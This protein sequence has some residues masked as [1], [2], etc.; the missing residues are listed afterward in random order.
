M[1]DDMIGVGS[2]TN[3]AQVTVPAIVVDGLRDAA[4]AEIG[5]PGEALDTAAF[6]RA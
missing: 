5:S 1:Q 6:A 3:G 4:Y 2:V